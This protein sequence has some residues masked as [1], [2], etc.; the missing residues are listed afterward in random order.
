M[1]A[2]SRWHLRAALVCLVLG[3]LGGVAA[4]T[5]WTDPWLAAALEP[6][7]LH[8]LVVGWATQM[9]F[10]VAVWMFP[11]PAGARGFGPPAL[12]WTAFAALNAGLALR[13]LGELVLAAGGPAA[14]AL[15]AAAL[16][17]VVAASAWVA[18]VWRRVPGR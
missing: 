16:V 11:R 17:Q 12:L 1:P 6:A 18:A 9:I 3:L 10:G 7:A 4:A 14:A 13:V 15:G 2:I 8:L 5:P